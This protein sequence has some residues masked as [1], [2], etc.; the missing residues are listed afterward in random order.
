MNILHIL[1]A[2][3]FDILTVSWEYFY[4]VWDIVEYSKCESL[5][6]YISYNHHHYPKPSDFLW[7]ITPP[8]TRRPSDIQHPLRLLGLHWQQVNLTPPKT[9][10]WNLEIPPGGKGDTSTNHQFFG[11]S[12]PIFVVFFLGGC[13][14]FYQMRRTS[15]QWETVLHHVTSPQRLY[16]ENAWCAI[17]QWSI[18][19]KQTDPRKRFYYLESL[20]FLACPVS[21]GPT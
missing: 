17:L 18:R 12:Y 20:H 19:I 3:I 15:T 8:E 14:W 16:K 1:S 10:G 7:R 13:N 5:T 21:L 4:R 6:L 2:N 9:N 11:G